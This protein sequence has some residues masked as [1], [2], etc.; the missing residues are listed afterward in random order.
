M[1]T[2]FDSSTVYDHAYDDELVAF[3]S[4]RGETAGY[5]TYWVAYPLAFLSGERLVYLPHLPYHSD[6][7]YSER[8]DRYQPYRDI[9]DAAPRV[10]YIT[11]GQPWLDVYLRQRLF[12]LGVE[13]EETVIGDYRIF[14][15]LSEAVGPADLGLG[16]QAA[17]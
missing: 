2:Q 10:A 13:F 9:V 16:P 1:T 5:S 7:R 11:A 12:A 3:L 8:D 17:P 14:H 6:F 4:E 15:S